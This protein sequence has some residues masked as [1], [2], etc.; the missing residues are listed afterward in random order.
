VAG[1]GR[2]VCYQYRMLR[3]RTLALLGALAML[4]LPASSLA[5]SAGD[6]QYQDP[7]AGHSGGGSHSG[8]GSGSGTGAGSGNTGG[9]RSG[10]GASTPAAATP[11]TGTSGATAGSSGAGAP[12]ATAAQSGS[13]QLPRTGFDVILTIELGLAMLLTGV[14]AQRMIVL[15]DRRNS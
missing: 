15:R 13:G 9:G 14:V 5:Q 6:D 12:Q 8:S 2:R 3:S 1:S 10:G 4:A 7:L 11:T